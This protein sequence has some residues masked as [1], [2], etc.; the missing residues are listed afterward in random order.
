MG[1]INL[2]LG[3]ILQFESELNGLTNQE[4]GKQIYR[5]FLKQN[6]NAMLKYEWMDTSEFLSKEKKKIDSVKDDLILKY[7]EKTE[8]GGFFVS[9]FI[10]IKDEQGNVT[11]RIIN[12]K[13]VEFEKEYATFLNGSEKEV[14]YPDM[15]KEDLKDIGNTTDD[16]KIIYKL[17]KKGSN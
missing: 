7:G 5:G 1:K 13:F 3:E 4:T 14:E 8:D 10:E 12:P 2:K 15:T 11:N 6:I 9:T 17:I 16:Y